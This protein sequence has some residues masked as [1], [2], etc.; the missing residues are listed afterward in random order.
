[1]VRRPFAL[2][3]SNL[4]KIAAFICL[5]AAFALTQTW[6]DEGQVL[7]WLSAGLAL[8]VFSDFV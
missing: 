5:V 6:I 7:A 1:M 2:T 8:Y 4:F 3:L